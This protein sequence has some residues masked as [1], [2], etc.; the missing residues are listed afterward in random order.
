MSIAKPPSSL[1]S[2][3]MGSAASLHSKGREGKGKGGGKGKKKK[4][5][6]K[7]QGRGQG[8]ERERERKEKEKRKKGG[9]IKGREGKCQEKK[10]TKQEADS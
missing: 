5:K 10:E 8:K 3:G 4:G 2:S 6:R 7:G 9:E 1:G